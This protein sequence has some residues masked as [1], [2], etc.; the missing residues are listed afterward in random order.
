M[1]VCHYHAHSPVMTSFKNL[2]SLK[3]KIARRIRQALSELQ[4]NLG[5]RQL[6][7][8]PVP[9]PMRS[10]RTFRTCPGQALFN[11]TFCTARRF[12]ASYLRFCTANNFVESSAR[13]HALLRNK[14]SAP[15][16]FRLK[17]F[18]A[19]YGRPSVSEL[20]KMN[21]CHDQNDSRPRTL[22]QRVQRTVPAALRLNLL[23]SK[24]F[25]RMVIDL[26]QLA[27]G[28][29]VVQGSYV[30]FRLQPRL[31]VPGDTLMSAEVVSEL[32]VNLKHFEKHICQLQR[33]LAQLAELGEL[34]VQVLAATNT[35]RVYFPNCDRERLE[36][37]LCEKNVVL[38]IVYEDSYGEGEALVE[39]GSVS[40]LSDLDLLSSYS[41][42]SLV[43]SEDYDDVLSGSDVR[44]FAVER[45]VE[46]PAERPIAFAPSA[47]VQIVDDYMWA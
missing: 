41:L 32:L 24:Q 16:H 28:A 33:D 13:L 12:Y 29:G 37:L 27:S 1:S 18:A 14:F 26:A 11:S 9:V 43:S 42:L 39:D 10:R 7:P 34:P 23:L 4:E 15:N 19:F 6:V 36:A 22:P 8:A 35:I 45:P 46:R 17:L 30:E 20:L 3:R 31:S 40:S 25:H 21:V 44:L 47:D 5:R 2:A 38:G